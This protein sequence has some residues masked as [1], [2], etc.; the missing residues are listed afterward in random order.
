VKSKGPRPLSVQ[1]S[2]LKEM[3]LTFRP[4]PTN[5]LSSRAKSRDLAF[6]FSGVPHFS[7][8]LREVG[9]SISTRFP[10]QNYFG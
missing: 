10:R 9:T 3:R 7:P 5:P 6:D 2:A 4:V 8:F 1:S